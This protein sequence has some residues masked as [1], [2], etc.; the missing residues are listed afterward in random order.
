MRV[1]INVELIGW[2]M[3]WMDNVQVIEPS[4]LK[5]MVLEK[6]KTMK[7]IHEHKMDPRNNG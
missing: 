2:I 1:E 5:D 6:L 3:M 4:I 7:S